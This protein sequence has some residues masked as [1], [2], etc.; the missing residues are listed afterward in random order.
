LQ[1]FLWPSVGVDN[2][3]TLLAKPSEFNN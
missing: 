1:G 2:L 3:Q